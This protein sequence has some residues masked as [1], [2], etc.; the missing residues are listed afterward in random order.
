MCGA[1]RY[2]TCIAQC[3]QVQHLRRAMELVAEMRSRGISA[4]VH[5]YSALM[6]GAVCVASPGESDWP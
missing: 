3:G 5:T 6:N 4:N 2:T 1:C